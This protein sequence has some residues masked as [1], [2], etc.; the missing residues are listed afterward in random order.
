MTLEAM[1]LNE[2][3]TSVTDFGAGVGQYVAYVGC[4]TWLFPKP[5]WKPREPFINNAAHRLSQRS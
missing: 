4:R 1:V 5:N 2:S 3:V